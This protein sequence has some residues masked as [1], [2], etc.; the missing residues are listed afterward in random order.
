M[1]EERRRDG[2]VVV[3]EVVSALW[4]LALHAALRVV[5]GQAQQRQRQRQRKD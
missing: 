4:S 5:V 2:V 1:A 3:V